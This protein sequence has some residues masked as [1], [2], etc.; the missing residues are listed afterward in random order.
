MSEP[1]ISVCRVA[2]PEG[3]KDYVTLTRPDVVFSDGLISEAILGVLKHALGP[4]EP[5]TPDVFAPNPI[6]TKFLA[7][8]IARHGP[9]QPALAAQ[10][11]RIGKGGV[12]LVDQRTPTPQGPVPPEDIIG[13]FGVEGGKVLPGSYSASPNHRLLTSN[14]FFRLDNALMECLQQELAVRSANRPHEPNRDP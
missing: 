1:S 10:A 3:F 5:I 6:F 4:E 14:G 9:E 2:T 7:E 13:V 11:K 12:F 8:V